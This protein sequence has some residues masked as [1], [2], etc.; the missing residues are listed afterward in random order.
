MTFT[1]MRLADSEEEAEVQ[2]SFMGRCGIDCE[3]CEY[4]TQMGCLGC[5]AAEGKLF[6]GEC[7]VAKCCIAKGHDHCGQ[8]QE[9]PSARLNALAHDPEHGDNGQR[10]LNLRAW[11]EMGC[12]A[13]RGD[14]NEQS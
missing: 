8:C 11:N 3:A 6:W 13:W 9:F 7:E 1:D 4:R 10:I 5:P 14:K 12:D 2:D